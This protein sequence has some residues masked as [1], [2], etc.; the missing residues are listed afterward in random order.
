MFVRFGE[1]QCGF[2]SECIDLDFNNMLVI[3]FVI[4][5]YH[6]PSPL[7]HHSR[8]PIIGWMIKQGA[9]VE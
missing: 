6:R 9:H 3:M 4:D 2:N 1:S 8:I 7:T 5:S